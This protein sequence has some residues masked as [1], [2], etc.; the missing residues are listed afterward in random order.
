MGQPQQY[1]PQQGYMPQQQQQQMGTNLGVGSNA[2]TPWATYQNTGGK[3]V[4]SLP[5]QQM[6]QQTQHMSLRKVTPMTSC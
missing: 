2:G 3:P 1:A 4:S 5:Q 6:Q